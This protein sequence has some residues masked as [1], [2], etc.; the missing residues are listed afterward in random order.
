[1]KILL[2]NA[3]L[4][5]PNH[6][7]IVNIIIEDGFVTKIQKNS[8][9][10]DCKVINCEGKIICPMFVDGHEH[11]LGNYWSG[12]GIVYSGVGTVVGCLAHENKDKH[13]QKL[14]EITNKLN[15]SNQ[16]EAYCLAGSK[17]Y[18]NDSTDFVLNN[19]VVVGVKTALFQPQRPR[20]NLSY[21]KLKRDALSTYNAGIK[22]GKKVQLHIHLDS[23]FARGENLSKEEIDDKK[24]D[25][26]GWIDKIVEDTGVPYSL[27]KLTHAQKYNKGIIE[28][29][30]KGCF[31]DFTAFESGYDADFDFIID[32]IKNKQ[33]D[34]SRISISSDLGVMFMERGEEGKEKPTSI[35]HT[36][37]KLVLNKGLMLEDVLPMVTAN[38]GGLLNNHCG[39][40]EKGLPC[41]LLILDEFLNIN[42]I[43]NFKEIYNFEKTYE[44]R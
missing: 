22:A 15:L 43:I 8:H 1:M 16:I 9:E 30:N 14:I 26:F 28:L 24:L 21:E 31:V 33:V 34:L 25:N 39:K 42:S 20:P 10:K 23:P 19:K 7:G 36:L 38:P 5:N 41:K 12:K 17:N 2:K 13:I 4:Y 18:I 27:F 6:I 37:K 40:I 35:L 29:A 11:L 44:L 32:A 3:N